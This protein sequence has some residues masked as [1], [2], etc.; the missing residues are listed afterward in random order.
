VNPRASSASQPS[1]L[2][3]LYRG[4]EALYGADSGL[5]PEALLVPHDGTGGI[6]ERLLMRETDDGA[7]EVGLSLAPEILA[8]V[9]DNDVAHALSDDA[10]GDTLPVLE[11]LSH[12]AYV[13]E[14]ARCERPISGLELETQ[15]EVDKLAVVLLHRWD[16]A[17]VQFTR[18][19]QRLYYDFELV[20][21]FEQ[22]ERYLTANRVA[23]GFSRHLRRCVDDG[24]LEDLRRLLRRFWLGSMNDKLAMASL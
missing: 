5:D 21:P 9:Q 10:L 18:L 22:V 1:N 11:G 24:R 6:R 3:R 20:A 12:L 7:L 16:D 2:Q 15:A 14:A 4:I 19:V 23:V 8:A 13:A 17:R